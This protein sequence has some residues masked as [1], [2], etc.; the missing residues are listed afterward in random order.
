M[1]HATTTAPVESQYEER[2]VRVIVAS[3]GFLHGPPPEGQHLVV[4][5]RTILCDPHVDPRMRELTG[6]N[7]IVR[8]HVLNTPGASTL[9]ANLVPVVLGIAAII[10]TPSPQWEVTKIAIGCAGG[11]HRSVVLA[12]ELTQRLI[13]GG[14]GAEVSHRD[15]Q[16]PVIDRVTEE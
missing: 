16:Q 5:V 9:V 13:D 3:F 14:I 15:I 10:S 8:R 6:L 11:R 2:F 12:N 7:L 1:T 4:D